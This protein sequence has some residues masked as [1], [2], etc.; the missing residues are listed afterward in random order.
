MLQGA[1]ECKLNYSNNNASTASA[2]H[3][4]RECSRLSG[5][6]PSAGI[7]CKG[8]TMAKD[9]VGTGRRAIVAE[10]E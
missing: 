6:D 8:A 2:L 5:L 10:E 4:C 9:V 1:V 3:A 7:C